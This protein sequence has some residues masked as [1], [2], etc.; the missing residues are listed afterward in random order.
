MLNLSILST[1]PKE[2]LNWRF[3]LAI[4]AIGI[5]GAARGL[6]EG[7]ISSQTSQK[8]FINSYG[9]RP[10]SDMQSNI[11]SM[12]Q[13]ASVA[14]SILAW[15]TSDKLGRIRSA[16]IHCLLWIIGTTVWITSKGNVG[17]LLAGR[18]IVGLG[19]GGTVVCAPTYLAEVAPKS[20]RGA[21]VGVFSG[22]VYVGILL[23]Y[24]ANLG[25]T[26]NIDPESYARVQIPTSLNLIFAAIPLFMSPLIRES[27]RW[28][29]KSGQEEQAIKNMCWLR[30]LREEHPYVRQELDGMREALRVEKEAKGP[31]WRWYHA[32]KD[33]FTSRENLYIL[34][35]VCGAQ[36]FGQF[37][38]GGSITIY[39]PTLFQIVSGSS[40]NSSI[41]TTAIFGV[42]K[43]VASL[44]AGLFILDMF[45]R[46]RAALFGI[47]LQ[48][49]AGMYIAVYLHIY[50]PPATGTK[51][52]ASAGEK[53]ASEA[54]IAMIFVSGIGW[55]CG[56]NSI[57]YLLASELYPTTVRSL[58]TMLAMATHFLMQYGSSRSVNPMLETFKPSGTFFFWAAE[59]ALCLFLVWFFLPESAGRSLEDM[60][61]LFNKPWYRIGWTSNAPHCGRAL[62]E[63]EPSE[64]EYNSTPQARIQR[65]NAAE[66]D[67]KDLNVV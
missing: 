37:S 25:V 21:V 35:L 65:E 28:L 22:T 20:L 24:C 58:G 19:V 6:D 51:I 55:A 1:V 42:I 33:M 44:L 13:I 40:T 57:Q 54:A 27:P 39:A 52:I 47:T 34:M 60:Q 62:D 49:I 38:G 16:Q 50:P 4:I 5:L 10:G 15:W 43:L 26:R 3:F 63:F 8:A 18:F 14:G 30:Q 23:G 56:F 66:K 45:G 41:F 67:E 61:E 31:T 59:A 36:V 53:R 17:Q 64:F 11:T 12:V 32:W 9:V 29:L 46:K 2:A 7:I 48:I